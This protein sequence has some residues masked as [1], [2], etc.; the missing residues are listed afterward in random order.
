MRRLSATRSWRFVAAIGVCRPLRQ[1]WPLLA[2]TSSALLALCSST[3]RSLR[4]ARSAG[5]G[6]LINRWSP[7]LHELLRFLTFIPL[8]PLN[9]IRSERSHFI[10]DLDV[11]NYT[12]NFTKFFAI[13]A[14]EKCI[15]YC[16]LTRNVIMQNRT[17][18]LRI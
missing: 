6:P 8:S 16:F 10:Y 11:D 2:D 5:C 13:S 9:F 17:S 18:R 7:A 15:F 3:L 14:Q 4:S 12:D 1:R